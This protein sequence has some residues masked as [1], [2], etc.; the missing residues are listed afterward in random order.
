MNKP[1]FDLYTRNNQLIV[2]GIIFA[3]SFALA[4]AIR[5]EGIPQWPFL[6]QFLIWAPYLVA[7]RL[8]VNWKVGVYRFIWRYVSL[9]DAIAITR[10]L[11]V[12]SAC[13]LALRLLYPGWA[14]FAGR[15]K[16]SLTVIA[17][18]FLLSVVGCLGARALRRI[19]YQRQAGRTGE[20][21]K[22]RQ[23]LLVGAGRAGVMVAK[24]LSAN[25]HVRLVGFLDDDPKKTGAVING[26]RVLGPLDSLPSVVAR[27]DVE[28]VVIC[29]PRPPRTLLKRVWALCEN[30]AL[31]AKIVP[32][33]EEVLQGKVNIAAF[34]DVQM[35]DLLGRETIEGSEAAGD[36]A[37]IYTGARILI[38]GAGGSIG[39]ELARQLFQLKPAQLVLLDKDENGL[40]D[41]FVR[42]GSNA[43]GPGV[44]PV[45]ADIRFR[46]RLQGIFTRFRPEVVFHAAAH[47]HVPLMEMN[48]CEAILNNV[49]GTRNLVELSGAFGVSQFVFISTD[50]AVR[51]TSIMGASKR[52]CEM[53]V[54]AHAQNGSTHFSCVRFGN[55]MGSR[56]SVIP[57]FQQQ[58]ARGGPVTVT[59]PDVQRFLMTIPEA[60]RLVIQAGTLGN[61]GEIFILDMGDP[62]PILDLARDL[63][64]L[65]GLRPG[66]D[67]QIEVTQL[68]PGEKLTEELIDG[69]TEQL[70]PTRFEK[71]R[72]VTGQPVAPSLVAEKLVALEKAARAEAA[73][74]IYRILREL[75]IGFTAN[76]VP[77]QVAEI[78][79]IRESVSRAKPA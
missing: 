11:C 31:P 43:G 18:E 5:F 69:A 30:L 16:I 59:H 47:K 23:V 44:H 3:T 77:P 40:N 24:E 2:D 46:E 72:V 48:P 9:P 19:L 15:L 21:A 74:D 52:V 62:V 36:L 35:A 50:K 39:S 34:R 32:T 38:T 61:A 17:L 37:Q 10:A 26:V 76:G 70:L 66:Q 6:K 57:L 56:G 55:V 42:L 71:I 68:R 8:Y 29:I 78:A 79:G 7:F 53:V 64:E 58:I 1:R 63:I 33:L 22:V 75:D 60:V 4:Y 45:V 28:E 54:Q 14:V 65:S 25:P 49:V 27:N 67:I 73:Q 51:P 41:I 12:P 20:V 13:L